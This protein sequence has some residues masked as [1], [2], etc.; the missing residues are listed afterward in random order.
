MRQ[1]NDN[2][3]TTLD[4]GSGKV[5][6]SISEIDEI[7]EI[8]VLGIG[9]SEVSGGIKG[10]VVVNIESTI[11]AINKAVEEAEIQAGREVKGL[12]VGISGGNIEAI[13]SKG[14]VAISGADKEIKENDIER[15]IE[16]A[17]AVAVPMDREILHIIP[18]TFM[19]DG[20]K[21]IK[22]PMGMV[23]TRLECQIHMITT[24]ISSIQNIVR[25]I[26][27][28]GYEIYDIVLQNIAASRA[29]LEDDEKEI[30]VLLIDIGSE[31]SK[32]S[33]Y[34][35]GAPYFHS[36]Y[37]LGGYLITNDIAAGLKISL[38]SAEQVK[39][40]YG[41]C[42]NDYVNKE[43]MIQVPSLGGRKPLIMPRQYLVEYIR[44]RI[45]EMFNFIKHDINQ[46]GHL[47]LIQGGIV[48]T[49][50]SSQ[51]P[52]I[53]EVCLETFDL[54][55]RLGMPKKLKGINDAI[56]FVDNAVSNG[57]VRWGYER[58]QKEEETGFKKDRQDRGDRGSRG[59]KS[60]LGTI[61]RIF[62][63]FF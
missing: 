3:I 36:I 31:T 39:L 54:P 6:V 27:R 18:Q 28:C 4:I 26:E 1:R 21:N 7:G 47:N 14:V 53:V 9:T 17:R 30:G 48:L 13:N 41:V 34:S 60:L 38:S 51:L 10:G 43:E 58:I 8:T 35:Q 2:L 45:E 24:P 33:I 52:G 15:V 23:G 25:C 12:F 62:D 16:A 56:N 50:G 46:H 61:K 29:V 63:E 44:P 20:S 59:E 11:N 42:H 40:A 49:G 32:I 57:L 22:N 5:I 19:V 55:A 37:P